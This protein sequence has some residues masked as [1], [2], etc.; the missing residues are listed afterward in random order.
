MTRDLEETL[1]EMGPEYRAV[2]ARLTEGLPRRTVRRRPR[3]FAAAAVVAAV[4][5]ACGAVVWRMS[6]ARPD[7]DAAAV[8]SGPR[9]Y[10]LAE[11]RTSEAVAEIVRTQRPDGGWATDFLTRQNALALRGE[12]GAEARLAYRRAVRNLRLRGVL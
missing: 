3:L 11:L 10:V 12:T 5:L 4:L 6:G 9:E 8:P 1:R 2:V 7:A